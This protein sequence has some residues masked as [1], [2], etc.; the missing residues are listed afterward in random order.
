MADF[1]PAVLRVAG[2]SL[3]VEPTARVLDAVARVL[4][5]PRVADA[6]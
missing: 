6:R 5:A 4:P 2:F 3:V 1:E